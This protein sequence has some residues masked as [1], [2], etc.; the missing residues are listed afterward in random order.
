MAL[1][2]KDPVVKQRSSVDIVFLDEAMDITWLENS[3]SDDIFLLRR[4]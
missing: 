4:K 3:S 2:N 1:L